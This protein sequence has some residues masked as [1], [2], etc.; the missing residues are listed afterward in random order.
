MRIAIYHPFYNFADNYSLSHVAKEQ[1][2]MITEAGHECHFITQVKFKAK[3]PKGVE[4][5]PVLESKSIKGIREA[6]DE[7]IATM[8]FVFTHDIVYL[9]AYKKYDKAIREQIAEFPEVRWLHWSHSAPNPSEKREPMENS[10][11]ILLNRWDLERLAEQYQIPIADCRLVYNPVSPDVWFDW[12]PFTKAI[13]D[14]HDLLDCDVILVLPFDTGRWEAKGG[15]KV[16]LLVEKLRE[17]K[18]NAKVVFI[19]A[20]ANSDGRRKQVEE[21]VK[22]KE[23][24][25]I[26]TSREDVNYEVFVPRR[27]VREFMLFGDVF[28]LL[29]VSEGCSLSMLEAALSDMLVI[30]NQ[31]FPPFHEFG[32]TDLVFWMRTSSDRSTT[33]YGPRGADGYF[34]DA[35]QN[36]HAMLERH[37]SK[38]LKRRTATRFNR[39]YIW[40]QYLEPLLRK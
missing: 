17:R 15:P 34:K 3:V 8:D 5:Y 14:K 9:D 16:V 32:R 18:L 33:N 35:A 38:R 40:A 13:V 23:E 26:F 4:V 1:M 31:D 19:N 28:P 25:L 7:L 24:Y 37:T 20:A 22:D 12:H 6:T 27:V 29:S 21:W 30:L 2:L 11:Y 10:T 39:H 36:L